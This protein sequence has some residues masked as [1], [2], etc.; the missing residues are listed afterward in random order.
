VHVFVYV[1]VCV[2]VC[3]SVC[4]S[5]KSSENK[6]RIS[7]DAMFWD[8]TRRRLVVHIYIAAEH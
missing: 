2:C 8:F 7:K 6:E 4:D 5:Y 1:C 3:V